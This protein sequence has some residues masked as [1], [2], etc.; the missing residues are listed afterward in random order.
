MDTDYSSL[1]VAPEYR[2]SLQVRGL[3]PTR[4]AK[5]AKTRKESFLRVFSFFTG[6]KREGREAEM[7]PREPHREKKEIE[8]REVCGLIRNEK[9]KYL[10]H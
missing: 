4:Y 9:K 6:R 8:L 2:I 3:K 1:A 7:A 5:Q 10:T